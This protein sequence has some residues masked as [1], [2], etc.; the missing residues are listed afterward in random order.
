MKSG[1]RPTVRHLVSLADW[2]KIK[3]SSRALVLTIM[4]GAALVCSSAGQTLTVL[5]KF[6][7]PD[8]D[9]RR[10]VPAGEEV[11]RAGPSL[12]RSVRP[13]LASRSA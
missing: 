11:G 5:H 9:T 2:P 4:L 3:R 12:T 10:D 6:N 7:G 13:T 1:F 8:G